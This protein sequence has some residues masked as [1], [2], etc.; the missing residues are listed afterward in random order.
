MAWWIS[1][2]C[3]LEILSIRLYSH[4]YI[5]L[6][7]SYCVLQTMHTRDLISK[8]DSF[9][10]PLYSVFFLKKADFQNVLGY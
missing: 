3:N 1:V 6:T 5:L 10:E 2:T 4:V 8:L 9:L 7:A